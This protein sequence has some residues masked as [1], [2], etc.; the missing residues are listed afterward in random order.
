MACRF[1][2][3]GNEY[4]KEQFI[5]SL[6]KKDQ[7]IPEAPYSKNWHEKALKDQIDEAVKK[8]YARVAWID[9]ATQA[10]RYAMSHSVDRLVYNKNLNVIQGYKDGSEVMYKSASEGE[11]EALIG[12]EPAKRLMENEVHSGIHEIKG[13]ALDI[14]GDGMKGFYDKILP[15]YARKYLKK[16]GAEVTK[17]KLPDGTEVWSFPVTKEMSEEVSTKGQALYA[18]GVGALAG[19]ETDD[20][21]NI[22]GFNPLYALAGATGGAI[23][24]KIGKGA[25]SRIIAKDKGITSSVLKDWAAAVKAEAAEKFTMNKAYER[26]V[27]MKHTKISNDLDKATI[28]HKA[29]AQMSPKAN[30][31]LQRY[32]VKDIT[33]IEPEYK[34]LEALGDNVNH[35][36]DSLS[37][38]LFKLG[39]I[40]E[41]TRDAYKGKYLKR[42]YDEHWF[43]NEKDSGTIS[44]KGLPKIYQRGKQL[45]T[46]KAEEAY[47]Y[48]QEF[49]IQKGLKPL[50]TFNSNMDEVLFDASQKGYFGEKTQGFIK[51]DNSKPKISFDRDWTKD[52]REAMGEIENSALTVPNTLARLA[53]EV[54]TARMFKK[55]SNNKEVTY[56]GD[57]TD[58]ADIKALGYVKLPS[59]KRY[60]ALSGKHVDAR[61]AQDLIAM[62]EMGEAMQGWL[63]ALSVWK[64][65]KTVWNAGAHVNNF[66]SNIMLRFLS[67]DTNPFGNMG[68]AHSM[69]SAYKEIEEI[70]V[71]QKTG[72]ATAADILQYQKLVKEN[73]YVLE[74]RKIGLFGKSQLQDILTN[75]GGS[76][77]FK[78]Q[79]S[80]TMKVFGKAN[81]ITQNL[82]SAEDGI[83]RLAMYITR[84]KKGMNGVKAQREIESILPDYTR[85]LP[86]GIR[87][88]KNSGTAP[89]IS[90]TYYVLPN[91]LKLGMKNKWRAAAVLGAPMILS[92]AVMQM[93]GKSN[94]DLPTDAVGRRLGYNV[95][96][97]G[98][99]DTI[100]VDRILPGFDI[101]SIPME[102]VVEGLHGYQE[103]K[104]VTHALWEATKGAIG[105]SSNFASSTLL[106]GPPVAAGFAL[107]SGK[108]SYSGRPIVG[109]GKQTDGQEMLNAGRFI[110]DKAIPVP[111]EAMNIYD[112]AK[113]Q[114]IE[115]KKRK[116][117]QDI[118]PRTTKQQMLKL[119]GVNTQTYDPK[120]TDK[121]LKKDQRSFNKLEKV[122]Q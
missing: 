79:K 100:K 113:G 11:L 74:A 6:I 21:G 23:A 28:L 35:H 18:N 108:D 111:M 15:D 40:D 3:N 75:F 104:S 12:K 13:E 43:G 76:D 31:L 102:A 70:M 68:E 16:W 96:N 22:T 66:S 2:I 64:Q 25:Y 97:K 120:A 36:I 44:A 92:E 26:A 91:V 42:L 83:V 41:A 37:E 114:I 94:S 60:G 59:S 61:V 4:N 116:Q 57:L 67:G 8:G 73:P 20:N 55:L 117:F 71:K 49:G 77:L 62:E 81:E 30:M 58:D 82:Y 54:Q 95:D 51:I 27:Q 34:F 121:K 98:H 72:A 33:E 86:E 52:E 119:V 80:T 9:G 50:D 87:M 14:G 101:A 69:M 89:F 106:S 39:V 46:D 99:I 45:E 109:S 32:M 90:W 5:D 122:F 110:V 85:P 107:I 65:S 17:E 84:R 105:T 112:F 38:E 78:E 10:Q 63:K 1:I 19:I 7:N 24:L 115:E 103:S 47:E 93:Q 48:L 118:V 29:M 56:M 88:L 53:N